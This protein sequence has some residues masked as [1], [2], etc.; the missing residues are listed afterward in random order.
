MTRFVRSSKDWLEKVH[1][2]MM[3]CF[4]MDATFG[5]VNSWN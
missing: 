1:V 3:G 5:G 4:N 2:C